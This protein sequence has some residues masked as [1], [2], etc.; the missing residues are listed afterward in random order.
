MEVVTL[1]WQFCGC[2][3]SAALGNRML[4]L[5]LVRQLESYVSIGVVDWRRE[6]ETYRRL[7]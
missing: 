7:R 4:W 2:G 5:C 6:K 3:G 1:L